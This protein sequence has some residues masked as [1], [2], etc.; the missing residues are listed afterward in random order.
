MN[1]K[2]YSVINFHWTRVVVILYY[3]SLSS[4]TIIIHPLES[5]GIPPILRITFNINR[6]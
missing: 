2:I 6:V 4:T 5:T 3:V 1:N